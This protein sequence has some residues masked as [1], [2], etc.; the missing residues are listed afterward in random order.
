MGN[1]K[2]DYRGYEIW[3]WAEG[4]KTPQ[5]VYSAIGKEERPDIAGY[6]KTVNAVKK[7]IDQEQDQPPTKVEAYKGIEINYNTKDG[8]YRV[9]I[10]NRTSKRKNLEEIHRVID[11]KKKE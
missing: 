6:M 5:K 9:K 3:E 8:M 2:M 1:K 7:L 11:K 10:G 4:E